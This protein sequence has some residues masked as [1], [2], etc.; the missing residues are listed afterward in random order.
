MLFRDIV[1]KKVITGCFFLLL[2]VCMLDWF[3]YIYPC[4]SKTELDDVFSLNPNKLQFQEFPVD[5]R[6]AVENNRWI[7]E[8]TIQYDCDGN[9]LNK[10]EYYIN[11]KDELVCISSSDTENE[12]ISIWNSSIDG[13]DKASLYGFTADDIFD[14]NGN[15]LHKF[16]K[17]EQFEENVHLYYVYEDKDTPTINDLCGFI[18]RSDTYTPNKGA[19]NTQMQYRSS[20][21][22]VSFGQYG[23]TS[24]TW[25][26]HPSCFSMDA[27]GNLYMV[28]S[29]TPFG[30][31]SCWFDSYGRSSVTAC[32]NKHGELFQY[33]IYKY[34]VIE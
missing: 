18:Q 22:I 9:I 15:V 1:F 34:S 16:R 19:N 6:I 7:P 11:A 33:T 5:F 28:V 24:H 8:S 30:F 13:L 17:D 25:V 23:Y 4:H 2:S 3:L 14:Q 27:N 29:L 10:K 31:W 21:E 32:Y 26:E 20:Y 12:E